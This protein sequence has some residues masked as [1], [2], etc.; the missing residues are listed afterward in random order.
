MK[1]IIY[2]PI[3]EMLSEHRPEWQHVFENEIMR[4]KTNSIMVDQEIIK[5]IYELGF[6]ID[7]IIYLE[8][9]GIVF[10]IVEKGL[11]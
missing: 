8:A 6:I 1:E 5:Q 3:R 2:E 10:S 11:R 4:I 7:E 9:R